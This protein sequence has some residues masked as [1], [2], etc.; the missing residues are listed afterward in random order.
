MAQCIAG[1]HTFAAPPMNSV[2]R[3][4]AMPLLV[5]AYALV[6]MPDAVRLPSL[7]G[8]YMEHRGDR[9]DLGV[10]DFIVLH[11]ADPA[12]HESGDGSHERLPFHHH[13]VLGDNCAPTMVAASPAPVLVAPGALPLV[14]AVTVSES[15]LSGHPH[16]LIQPPRC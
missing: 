8:H 14:K 3:R 11:Y 9:P 10:L 7:V 2:F 6:L 1:A 16:G 12:H 13:H 15:L 5:L 4:A